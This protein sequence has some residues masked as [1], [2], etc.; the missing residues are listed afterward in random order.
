MTKLLFFVI[1]NPNYAKK[2]GVNY[3]KKVWYKYQYRKLNSPGNTE[4]VIHSNQ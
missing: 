2:F 1:Y 3:S 4:E